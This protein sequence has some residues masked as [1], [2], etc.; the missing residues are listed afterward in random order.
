MTGRPACSLTGGISGGVGTDKKRADQAQ[1]LEANSCALFTTCGL[2]CPTSGCGRDVSEGSKA[3]Y[4]VQH[5][6]AIV[7]TWRAIDKFQNPVTIPLDKGQPTLSINSESHAF[8]E[9]KESS[10]EDE[11]LS[12]ICGTQPQVEDVG[13]D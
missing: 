10:G 3:T 11:S 6:D 12:F 1:T 2:V 9:E 4:Q 7:S 5:K 13:T 8:H